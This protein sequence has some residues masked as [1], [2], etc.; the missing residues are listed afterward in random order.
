MRTALGD[1]EVWR[2]RAATKWEK[3]VRLCLFSRTC[4]IQSMSN[5][6][7]KRSPIN[8]GV[9]GPVNHNEYQRHLSDLQNKSHLPPDEFKRSFR[10]LCRKVDR[11][12]SAGKHDRIFK[13]KWYAC[14]LAEDI[15]RVAAGRRFSPMR[16]EPKL[17]SGLALTLNYSDPWA[18]HFRVPIRRLIAKAGI[19]VNRTQ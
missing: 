9:C 2:R 15:K 6:R 16:L 12:Y 4:G 8:V 18:E 17:L 19:Q 14:F 10:R 11:I 7:Q 1:Y 13:G 5:Y 3:W